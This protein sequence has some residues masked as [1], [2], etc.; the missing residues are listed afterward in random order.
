[1]A[2]V[3]SVDGVKADPKKMEAITQM[4]PPQNKAELLTILGMVNYLAKFLPNLSDVTAQMQDLLKKDAEF[5]LEV[6]RMLYL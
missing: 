3:I 1:M 5:V 4:P 6:N 2:V